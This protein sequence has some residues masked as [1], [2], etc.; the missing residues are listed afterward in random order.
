MVMSTRLLSTRHEVE[1]ESA[2]QDFLHGKG[3]TDG[4]PVIAPTPERVL[5]CLDAAVLAPDQVIGIE[6][7]RARSITAEKA[8]V[9]AVLAGCQPA[10]FPVI[11]AILEAMCRPS[12]CC[13]EPLP[14]PEAARSSWLS[15]GRCASISAWSRPSTFS[16]TAIRPRR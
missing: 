6:P 4:L 16:A 11:A 8:A 1:N 15:M 7:V 10:H 12:S 3:W 5:A 2:A 9:N 14:A 13:T